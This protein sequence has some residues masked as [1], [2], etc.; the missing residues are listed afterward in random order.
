MVNLTGKGHSSVIGLYAPTDDATPG[1]KDEFYNQLETTLTSLENRRKIILLE[2]LNARVGR[3]GDSN[4]V[5]SLVEETL[6]HGQN[7][8]ETCEVH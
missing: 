7:L 4:I 8:L 5:I 3:D 6:N 1:E 2:D